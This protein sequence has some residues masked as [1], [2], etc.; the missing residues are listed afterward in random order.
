MFWTKALRM[1]HLK[2]DIMMTISE[3]QQ[4]SNNVQDMKEV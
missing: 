4:V 2:K 3:D 1:Q